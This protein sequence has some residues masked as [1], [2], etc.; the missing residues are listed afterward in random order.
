MLR[1]DTRTRWTRYAD[2]MTRDKLAARRRQAERWEAA[3]VNGAEEW[4]ERM[5]AVDVAWRRWSLDAE[6]PD[7]KDE[8]RGFL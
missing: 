6:S 4:E 5:L 7:P 2:R 3:R 8:D 1:M